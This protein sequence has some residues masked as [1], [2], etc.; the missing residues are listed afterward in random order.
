MKDGEQRKDDFDQESKADAEGESAFGEDGKTSS[1]DK[2]RKKKQ[3]KSKQE[4][5]KE[6]KENEGKQLEEDIKTNRSDLRTK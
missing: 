3:I 1:K 2:R 6:F 5:F 4:A